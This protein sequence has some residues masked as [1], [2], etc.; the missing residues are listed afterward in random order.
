MRESDFCPR[1]S[2]I[3]HVASCP[4]ETFFLIHFF[5]LLN[6]S[7][8]RSGLS[9][10]VDVS[11]IDSEVM[12]QA[13]YFHEAFRVA[14]NKSRWADKTPQYVSYF[15]DIVRYAPARTQF[16]VLFR[17]PYDIAYSIYSRGWF[18]ERYDD[19]LLTNT[20]IYVRKTVER[21]ISI[22]E[23][24]DVHSMSYETLVTDPQMQLAELCSYLNE[25][26]DS[27]MLEPWRSE[28]NFGT[29]DPLVRAQS[30]FQLSS[31]NWRAF[32]PE[33]MDTLSHHLGELCGRLG[34][35]NDVR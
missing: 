33:Q 23:R 3:W 12:R 2:Q 10:I 24:N 13:F 9:G 30:S 14:N 31:D 8:S 18:L 19:D 25:T 4:P 32:R 26:W 6:D 5:N 29:E 35:S 16:V 7:R 21:L 22:S 1:L 15:E 11:S 20:C 28:H 34:Y 27:S 17:N